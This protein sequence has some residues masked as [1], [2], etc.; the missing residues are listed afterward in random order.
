[1]KQ[2]IKQHS[3]RLCSLLLAVSLCLS[4]MNV[5]AFATEKTTAE[6]YA[7]LHTYAATLNEDDYTVE[8][9]EEFNTLWSVIS[10]IN[11]IS[12]LS[13]S[14]QEIWFTK[15]SDAINGLVPAGEEG[16]EGGS[17][18]EIGDGNDDEEIDTKTNYEKYLELIE[19][20]ENLDESLYTEESWAAFQKKFAEVYSYYLPQAEALYERDGDIPYNYYNGNLET[21]LKLLYFK[22]TETVTL[23]H[24]ETGIQIIS[25]N[26]DLVE[27]AWV[28]VIK[29]DYSNWPYDLKG[30]WKTNITTTSAIYSA[31]EIT[32]KD[33]DGNAADVARNY[34]ITVPIPK[35]YDLNKLNVAIT[36]KSGA[37]FEPDYV[38]DAEHRVLTISFIDYYATL[39]NGGMVFF[40]NPID[41]IDVSTLSDGVYKVNADFVKHSDAGISSM[42]DGTLEATAILVKNGDDVD[43]YL[44][45]VPIDYLGAPSYTGGLWCEVGEKADGMLDESSMTVLAYYCNADGSLMD[46]EIYDAIT[47][48]AC[49]KLIKLALSNNCKND[50][51]G[52]TLA[53]SSPAMASMNNMAFEEIIVDDLLVNLLISNPEYLGSVEYAQ[54][55]IPVYDKSALRKEIEFAKI[56]YEQEYT[57]S[58]YKKLE[59]AVKTAESVYTAAYSDAVSASDAYKEQI[60]LLKTAIANLEEST[61]MTKAKEELQQ[62]IDTAKAVQIGNKTESAYTKLQSAIMAAENVLNNASSGVNT[63]NAARAAIEDAVAAFV[64]SGE[65]SDISKD[66]LED[67][68]YSV[69]ADMIKM[70]RV[71]KS[72]A[73]NAIN[74]IV[75]LEVIDGEYFVTLDFKGITIENRFGYLKNLSYYAEG[76]TY[77]P[78]G[79]VEGTLIS[80]EVLST[81]KD[82]DGKDVIDQYNDANT[83]YPDLV[84]IKIVPSAF[85]DENGYVPLHV[86]VPIMEAIAEGNGDQDVLMKIDWTTLKATTEDDPGFQPEKPVIQSPAVDITDIATGVKIYA[87]KGVFGEGVKLVVNTVTSGTDYDKAT[88]AIA[89]IGKKFKLYEIHFEDAGNREVRPNGTVMVSY[90]IPEGYDATKIV[91]Y[92]I[93]EDGTKTLIKGLAEGNYYTV[94]TKSFSLYALVERDSIITDTPVNVNNGQ[95]ENNGQTEKSAQTGNNDEAGNDVPTGNNAQTGNNGTNSGNTVSPQTGDN[96]NLMLWSLILSSAGMFGVMPFMKKRRILKG[97]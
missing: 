52:Y 30:S 6:Q 24:E 23:K 51:G 66:N 40:S 58:S 88:A 64:N 48:I 73:D 69:Y 39:A 54:D 96:S 90:P 46:N 49:V 71:S 15:L 86:F 25:N 44:S 89:E 76:Y 12:E 57:A 81:Q 84:K 82:S 26:Y 18:G 11:D 5:T 19:Y 75:K 10:S 36:Q 29:Y 13:E 4:T 8:S 42:A 2:L 45:F 94:V 31:Y 67:G 14:L 20:A 77:G 16:G 79:T 53:V 85:A 97:E 32:V 95:N 21:F 22:D 55:K 59:D 34:E 78:Y 80:A 9:W 17:G 87:D 56:F 35:E 61:E 92:R 93:N 3:R 37:R 1:M 72:M 63:I 7:E 28:D 47:E 91:V 38:I 68:I 65:A 60:E 70:D 41:T 33:S 43:I 27:N 74:H 50:A 62:A 83:L